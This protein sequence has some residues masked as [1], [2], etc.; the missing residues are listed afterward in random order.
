MSGLDQQHGE[1]THN[2]IVIVKVEILEG[3]Y[4]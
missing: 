2:H 4:A 1:G 3:N